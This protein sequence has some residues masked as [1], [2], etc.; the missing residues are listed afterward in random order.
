VPDAA[1]ARR[2]QPAGLVDLAPP[3]GVLD[4]ANTQPFGM[5]SSM[6]TGIS[7]TKIAV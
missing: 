6:M 4:S 2:L 5:S 1:V 7:L 3:E